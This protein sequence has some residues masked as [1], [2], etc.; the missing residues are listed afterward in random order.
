MVQVQGITPALLESQ[1]WRF[2]CTEEDANKVFISGMHLRAS[3]DSCFGEGYG[4]SHC[5]TVACF[6]CWSRSSCDAIGVRGMPS[7]RGGMKLHLSHPNISVLIWRMHWSRFL[8]TS[9]HGLW[10]PAWPKRFVAC[11]VNLPFPLLCLWCPGNT[12][13]Q[14]LLTRF[15]SLKIH[16][17]REGWKEV[18]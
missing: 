8:W 3:L 12:C 15:L 11:A 14:C 6:Q 2:H 18:G 1:V 4:L 10:L 5:G 17:V 7:C 9:Q 16:V 13:S